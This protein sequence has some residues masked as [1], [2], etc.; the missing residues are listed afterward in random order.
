MDEPLV[1]RTD[2]DGVAVIELHRPH[3]KNA[4]IAPML[5]ELAMEG[6]A[7]VVE[8]LAE[9]IAH[10]L[11]MASVQADRDRPLDKFLRP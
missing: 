4:I 9:Q 5:D 2:R 1:R 6:R 10:E 3:R 11:R 7:F 8:R